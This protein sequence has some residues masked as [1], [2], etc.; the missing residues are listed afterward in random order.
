MG[1]LLGDG[2]Y[3]LQPGRNAVVVDTTGK[4]P[5]VSLWFGGEQPEVT[6]LDGGRY[7]EVATPQ[8]IQ[9]FDT[10]QLGKYFAKHNKQAEIEDKNM[11]EQGKGSL[12]KRERK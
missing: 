12:T 9:L 7:F 8:R 11:K 10:S 4:L 5:P 3:R 1:L 2:K 6:I